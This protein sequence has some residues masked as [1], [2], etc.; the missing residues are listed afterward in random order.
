MNSNNSS[1]ENELKELEAEH[2][3]LNK[4]IDC[5][6]HQD[7][8]EIS[9]QRLKKRRLYLRDRIKEIKSYPNVIA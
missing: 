1:L 4:F 9:V 5:S 8:D 2:E 7:I 6:N 3:D